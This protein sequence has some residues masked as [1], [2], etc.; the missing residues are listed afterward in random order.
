MDIYN[1][2]FSMNYPE[3]NDLISDIAEIMPFY[4]DVMTYA[5]NNY[6]E[7]DI[8]NLEDYSYASISPTPKT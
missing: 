8:Y 7:N 6:A 1:N 4:K 2:S 5:D 3:I